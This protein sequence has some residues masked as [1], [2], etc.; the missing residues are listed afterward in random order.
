MHGRARAGTGVIGLVW[1]VAAGCGSDQLAPAAPS[2]VAANT[3]AVAR[4][5]PPPLSPSI[6]DA[7]IRYAL[8]PVLTALEAAVPRRFGDIDR[9]IR[10]PSNRRQSFAFA[11]SRTPFTVAF[12]GTRLTLSTVVSYEGRGWYNP[13]FAPEV[14]ASCGTDGN[15]PRVRIV[16]TT[17][18]AVDPTWK[19]RAKS[20]V[21]TVRPLTDTE[22]DQCRV[23]MFK[24]DVTDKVVAALRPQLARKMP[25]VD[26]KI[27][28]FDLRT[29]VER[30]Y[31]LLNKSIRIRDSLWLQ[32]A[33]EDVRLGGLRLE[34]SSLVAD[35]RLFARPVMI[36]GARPANITTT[37]PPL[38][39]AVRT[40]GDSSHLLL[41]GLLGYDAAS[42]LLSQQ[43]VGRSIRRYNRKIT[44]RRSRVYPLNDGR[45]VLALGV[46]GAVIGEAYFIGTPTLDTA[47]SMLYVPD[48]DFDVQTA[49]ALVK[50]LAW[51]KKADLLQELRL[52][53]RVP[54][55]PILEETRQ[56]VEDAL[57]RDLAEGVQL[58]G[59][60]TTGRVVD[61][62]A[63]AQWL[64][65]RAEA[66]GSLGLGIDRKITIKRGASKQSA[67]PAA[68]DGRNR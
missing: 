1:M 24:I 40:V 12:D 55:A 13:P 50:S 9:R 7:P 23:T 56:R 46:D 35:V 59:S 32:L 58:T 22:R 28:A 25:Q 65:V 49:N 44:I 18:I 43:L 29:R 42:A 67:P 11:A 48:L 53:A 20:L 36:T 17:D 2:S 62:F 34:D 8:E 39:Q 33:P 3:A 15:R 21:R 57:N 19:V 61:V 52:R 38:V 37:L 64:L 68:I 26:R 16:I 45:I 60:V 10:V 31:N 14:S 51:L 5:A 27:G 6:V 66:I 63:D 4:S 47:N 41:E 54:L 30:W